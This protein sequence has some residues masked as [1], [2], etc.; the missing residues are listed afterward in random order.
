[1]IYNFWYLA[2]GDS[3]FSMA[4][5][6]RT[7]PSAVYNIVRETVSAIITKLKAQYLPSPTKEPWRKN[8]ER[9]S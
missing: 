6:Y 1:M 3:Q 5:H 4:M 8:E 2:S 9:Y 7:S